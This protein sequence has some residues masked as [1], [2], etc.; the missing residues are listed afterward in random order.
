[1]KFRAYE[2]ELNGIH[3]SCDVRVNV[4]GCEIKDILASDDYGNVWGV[5]VSDD[6]QQAVDCA[7]LD[8]IEAIREDYNDEIRRQRTSAGKRYLIQ[9]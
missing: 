8:E 5:D 2:F 7:F 6:I 1:M 4:D 9:E 3:Y